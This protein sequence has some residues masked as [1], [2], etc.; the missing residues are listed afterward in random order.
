MQIISLGIGSVGGF[1]LGACL[2]LIFH[3]GAAVQ[4][5][6]AGFYK[7]RGGERVVGRRTVSTSGERGFGV[8]DIG[9]PGWKRLAW[10][11][12]SKTKQG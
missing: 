6:W 8:G 7:R 5:A 4:I 10:R 11:S 3:V 9:P 2:F 12:V 1:I